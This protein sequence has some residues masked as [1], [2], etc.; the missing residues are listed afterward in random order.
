MAEIHIE[1]GTH[2]TTLDYPAQIEES[3]LEYVEAQDIILSA[4]TTTQEDPDGAPVTRSAQV[5]EGADALVSAVD[6]WFR[7]QEVTPERTNDG[8]GNFRW[9]F[10]LP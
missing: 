8:V 2:G 7:E 5:E 10:N 4:A 1:I 3:L 9:E 6:S